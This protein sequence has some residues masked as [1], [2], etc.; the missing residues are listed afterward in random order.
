MT[1]AVTF[2]VPG[3]VPPNQGGSAGKACTTIAGPQKSSRAL[4]ASARRY[5]GESRSSDSGLA[6]E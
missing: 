5:R 3:I 6:D 2:V 1:G 4:R